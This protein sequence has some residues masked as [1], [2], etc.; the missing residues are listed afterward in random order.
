MT[1]L[2]AAVW[3]AA[4]RADAAEAHVTAYSG[5]HAC[6]ALA[7]SLPALLAQPAWLPAVE[8]VVQRLAPL[9]S[10]PVGTIRIMPTEVCMAF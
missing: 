7:Y 9:L 5:Y 4:G 2:L 1:A 3:N 6:H 10:H 8:A